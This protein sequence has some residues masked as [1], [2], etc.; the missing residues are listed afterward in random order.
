MLKK[1]TTSKLQVG[2]F[3]HDLNC[4]WMDHPFVR[5]RFTISTED[6]IARI[7]RAGIREVIIDAE[8]GRDIDDAPTLAELSEQTENAVQL[9][10]A[11]R[12]PQRRVALAEELGNAALIR[13]Q[14]SSLVKS[15]MQ[16]ARLGRAIDIDRVRPVIGRVTE[17]ILRNPGALIG[18]MQIKSKDDY[19]FLHSV[20]VCTLLVAFASSRDMPATSKRSRDGAYTLPGQV[21]QVRP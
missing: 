3:L 8:R 19:T 9:M 13:R 14:A 7:D 16:D 2:M 1:V 20:S 5:S 15:V 11:A 10:A 18:M 6:E 17:S 12:V 21:M 4:D